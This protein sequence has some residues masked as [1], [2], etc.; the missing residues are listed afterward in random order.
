MI[1]R[2][3]NMALSAGEKPARKETS[4]LQGNEFC[5]PLE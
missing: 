1:K 3:R 2:G 4:V 5:Q